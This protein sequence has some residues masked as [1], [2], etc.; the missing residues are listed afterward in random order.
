[1]FQSELFLPPDIYWLL[2]STLK[3]EYFFKT[4]ANFNHT[5][6]RNIPKRQYY[7][8]LGVCIRRGL[9]WKLDL[10][11]TLVHNSEPQVMQRHR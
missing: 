3:M 1:M 8:V 2:A 5:E 10:L 6:R 7:H 11:T 4:A 9:D